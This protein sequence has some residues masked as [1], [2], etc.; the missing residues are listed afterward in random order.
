MVW[1]LKSITQEKIEEFIGFVNQEQGTQ[2]DGKDAEVQRVFMEADRSRLGDYVKGYFQ[3]PEMVKKY[4]GLDPKSKKLINLVEDTTG[5]YIIE[6]SV[7]LHLNISDINTMNIYWSRWRFNEK[8][9][10]IFLLYQIL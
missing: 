4:F 6:T 1:L 2:I 8:V 3:F 5:E 9:S 7:W 10:N